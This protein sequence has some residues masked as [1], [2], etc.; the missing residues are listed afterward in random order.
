M[1]V[2]IDSQKLN[3]P[4]ENIKVDL[5]HV[6]D[7]T[8]D[9]Y[10]VTPVEISYYVG[11]YNLSSSAL[12]G[13]NNTYRYSNGTATF[14][15]AL[16]EGLY[17]VSS[18]FDAI[19]RNITANGN[20]SANINYAVNSDN[21]TITIQVTPPYTFSIIQPNMDLLGFNS[22]QIISTSA[23]SDNPINFFPHKMLY[24]HLRQIKNNFNYY[25]GNKS[26]ILAR[27][28]IT[29]DNFGTL[30]QHKFDRPYVNILDN[31]TI[32]SLELTLTDEDNNIIDFHGMPV[33]YTLEINKF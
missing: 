1:K 18:Y 3:Q 10:S 30:V 23:T 15:N 12:T 14:N 28:P 22:T 20:N 33:F 24:V 25:N 9:K 2:V 29:E 19:K 16:P 32:S 27:I 13:S 31:T 26:D 7:N 17:S 4:G 6:L 5:Q 11:Y 8:C 21:G